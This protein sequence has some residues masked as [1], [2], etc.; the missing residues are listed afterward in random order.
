MNI[1]EIIKVLYDSEINGEVAWFSE[2]VWQVKLGDPLGGASLQP[3]AERHAAGYDAEAIVARA[4][5]AEW[6]RSNA[7]WLYPDSTFARLYRDP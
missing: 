3:D 7:V 5:F 4:E 1:G 2:S 6:L